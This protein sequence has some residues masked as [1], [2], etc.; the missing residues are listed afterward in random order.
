M[1]EVQ[2]YAHEVDSNVDLSTCGLGPCVGIVVGY[3]G[4]VSMYHAPMPNAG[5]ISFFDALDASIPYADRSNV[6]PILAGC[7]TCRTSPDK[8]IMQ[9][10]LWVEKK[11]SGMGFGASVVMWGDGSDI[12][13]QNLRTSISKG[14]VVLEKY[15]W[16]NH[17]GSQIIRLW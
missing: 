17:V 12:A 6:H 11:L 10:R 16:D 3:N 7:H 4:R 5:D 2:M 14:E 15:D 1:I 9:T 8:D 13:S